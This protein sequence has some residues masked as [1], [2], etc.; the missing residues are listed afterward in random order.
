LASHPAS[1]NSLLSA[2][3]TQ[4][5]FS[6]VCRAVPSEKRVGAVAY[7]LELPASARIHDVFQVGLLKPLQGTPPSKTPA[8]PPLHNGCVLL[9]PERVLGSSLRRGSWHILIQWAGLPSSDATWEPIEAFRTSF[10]S[11]QLED[12]LFVEGGEMLCTHMRG[13]VVV[14]AEVGAASAQ[15]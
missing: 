9:Q 14:V 11:F 7:R 8:L 5:S 2:W 15:P 3:T 6:K 13:G 4:Q 1:P 10:P 12:E